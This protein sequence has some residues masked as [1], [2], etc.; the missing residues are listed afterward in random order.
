MKKILI[1]IMFLISGI[2]YSQVVMTTDYYQLGKYDDNK[3]EYVPTTDFLYQSTFFK[4]NKSETM[5]THVTE[6]LSSDYVI[7]SFEKNEDGL[8]VYALFR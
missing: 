3:K 5:F 4:F 7:L 1:I 8:L 2:C 6:D